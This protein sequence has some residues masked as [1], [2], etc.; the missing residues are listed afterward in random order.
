MTT[1]SKF[2]IQQSFLKMFI[3]GNGIGFTLYCFVLCLGMRHALAEWLSMTAAYVLLCYSAWLFK[4]CLLSWL[5][6]IYT[7][8]IRCCIIVHRLGWFGD[9]IN[10]AHNIA[11]LIGMLLTIYFFANINKYV[12]NEKADCD[13]EDVKNVRRHG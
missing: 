10:V 7:Y 5:F 4:L 12:K 9:Y 1:L 3:I 8:L 2:K 13:C 6:L 11:F